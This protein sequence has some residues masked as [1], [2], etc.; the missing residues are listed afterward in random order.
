VPSFLRQF[1]AQANVTYL[2]TRVDDPISAE[3]RSRRIY[4]VSKWTYN[5][6]GMYEANG[7]TARLSYNKQSSFLG[8]PDILA[9]P[10]I[11]NRGDD[12]YIQDGHPAGRLDLSTSYDVTPHFTLFFDWTN[13]TQ[14]PNRYD[15][16]SARNGAPRAEYTRYFRFTE[17]TLSGGLRFRFGGGAP[18]VAPLPPAPVL[19]PPPPPVVEQPAPPAPPPP[20]PPAAPERG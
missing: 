8:D 14:N 20:P 1:G 7:L 12:I 13:I 11:Q 3:I 5:L 18:R 9:P 16:S 17:T 4:G 15:F 2:D 6:V 19:P 10:G